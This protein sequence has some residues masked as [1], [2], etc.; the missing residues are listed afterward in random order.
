LVLKTF[1]SFGRRVTF[2]TTQADV[3]GNA[4]T[5]VDAIGHF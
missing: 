4:R 5:T 1:F 3:G 2:Q